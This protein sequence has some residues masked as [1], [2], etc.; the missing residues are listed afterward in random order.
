[1][2]KLLTYFVVATLFSL[3]ANAQKQ[4]NTA[5]KESRLENDYEAFSAQNSISPEQLA[6]IKKMADHR[7][8]EIS[9]ALQNL[10]PKQQADLQKE[11]ERHQ[12]EVKRITGINAD[13]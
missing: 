8:E 10:S 6:E 4:R 3:S 7:V 1:M 13:F 2:K 9:K 5:A 12:Q 11:M